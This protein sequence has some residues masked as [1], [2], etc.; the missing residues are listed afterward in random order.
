MAEGEE[1]RRTALYEDHVAAGGRMVPF[2]GFTLPV[3]YT[4]LVEEHTAVR[5]AAGLF[6]VSHMGRFRFTGSSTAA[7]LDRLVTRR[8]DNLRPG[9]IRY[10][11]ITNDAVVLGL[12]LALLALL[13]LGFGIG[14]EIVQHFLPYREFSFL[15]MVANGLGILLAMPLVIPVESLMQLRTT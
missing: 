5:T 14:M 15:D 6:D 10:A 13:L 11:L 12:L 3:Q 8:V 4:S 9:Q 1:A 7:V 2:A